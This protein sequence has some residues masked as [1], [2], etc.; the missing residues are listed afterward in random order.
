MQTLCGLFG[1]TRQ[2]YY[3]QLNKNTQKR[4]EEDFILQQV[5]AIRKDMPRIGCKKL[6]VILNNNGIR[7]GRD[8]LLDMLRANRMLVKRKK[9]YAVTTNSKHWMKKYPNLIRGFNFNAPNQLWVSDIT[10]I[11]I[12][13]NFVYLSLITDV[14]SHKILGYNLSETLERQGPVN[15]L[16][17]ALDD[18]PS[19]SR[20]GLIHHSDRGVQ[21]CSHD[22]VKLLNENDIR[23][24]MTENGDPYQNAV[25][26]RI[27]GI[28]KD[29]WLDHE[30]FKCFE[31]VKYRINQIIPIYN[32]KRPHLS[33]DMKTPDQTYRSSGKMKKRWNKV[34]YKKQQ[35]KTPIVNL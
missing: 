28:L 32:G 29:E 13:G 9:K 7:I 33:C 12:D 20:Y 26:E 27:N 4:L 2:A 6:H 5:R 15:A 35:K 19:G 3:K 11:P 16:R 34:S 18:I 23:I 31:Q 21:Y 25:A 30:Q 8:N 22:Y 17:M 24:S 14:Y 10:Y 1:Y